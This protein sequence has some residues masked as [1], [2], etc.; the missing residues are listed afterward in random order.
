MPSKDIVFRAEDDITFE[1]LEAGWG[2]GLSADANVFQLED[3]ISVRT[4]AFG[5]ETE[6]NLRSR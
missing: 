2:K 4:F 5:Y 6:E 3:D 1:E